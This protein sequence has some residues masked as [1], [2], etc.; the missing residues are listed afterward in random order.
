M[1]STERKLIVVTGFGPFV[2]HEEVNASWEAVQLLPELLSYEG[3]DY[4]LEKIM[5]PVEYAA[6]DE[7]VT[8]IWQRQP[9]ASIYIF[10]L[11]ERR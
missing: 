7:A 2:G 4:Q 9:E 10:D 11:I 1:S 6:V 3:T 8:E 5:V